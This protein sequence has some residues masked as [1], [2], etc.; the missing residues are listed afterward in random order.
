MRRRHARRCLDA[1]AAPLRFP[2]SPPSPAP[3]RHRVQEFDAR[4]SRAGCRAP[5]RGH[6][7]GR[8]RPLVE[9]ANA[10]ACRRASSRRGSCARH[11]ARDHRTRHRIPDAIR[12]LQRELAPPRRRS[13]DP[14]GPVRALPRAGG[15]E[16]PRQRH[17]LQDDRR[18]G[19]VQFAHPRPD[20]RR[21]GDD[22]AERPPDADG[23]RELRRTL[24]HGAG[25]AE[26][27]R[28]PSGRAPA[29]RRSPRR[30]WNPI[31][32]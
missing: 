22:R 26:I 30:R 16:A 27:L 6:H 2:A 28:G 31:S 3:A 11:R 21:R 18:P 24:G 15:G 10:A 23:C 8:Q 5:A 4:H 29:T 13:V 20:C 17:P 32:R 1:T 14:H 7:H 12:V 9:A 25:G 19:A